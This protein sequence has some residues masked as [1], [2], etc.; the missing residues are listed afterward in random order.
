MLRLRCPASAESLS[1]WPFDRWIRE[2]RGGMTGGGKVRGP[3]LAA[4]GHV[5][6]PHSWNYIGGRSPPPS[7]VLAVRSGRR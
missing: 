5:S 2:Q 3:D 6:Y 4:R 1:Q 7:L